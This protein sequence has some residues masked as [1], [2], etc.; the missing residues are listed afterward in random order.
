MHE[1]QTKLLTDTWVVATWDEFIQAINDPGCEK[2][3]GYYY[4][5]E[6][7]IE[8]LPIGPDRASDNTIILFAVN[9]GRSRQM[10]N[11]QVGA[12]LLEQMQN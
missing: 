2:A 7:R 4:E 1:L 9:L 11:T 12:W 8:M 3:K 10:D 5:G 6:L